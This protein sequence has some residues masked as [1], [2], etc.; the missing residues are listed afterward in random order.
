MLHLDVALMVSLKLKSSHI[1][2]TA[3]AADPNNHQFGSL[4]SLLNFASS[5][6]IK[7]VDCGHN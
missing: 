6:Y 4:N 1:K 5:A 3:L 2:K 7:I